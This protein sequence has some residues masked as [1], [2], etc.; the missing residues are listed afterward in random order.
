MQDR[1]LIRKLDWTLIPIVNIPDISVIFTADD[2][3]L[4]FIPP[5]LPRPNQ[6]W[7]C[8]NRWLAEIPS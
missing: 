8:E 6:Y 7:Q 3:A 2:I 5:R 1:K 4:Y